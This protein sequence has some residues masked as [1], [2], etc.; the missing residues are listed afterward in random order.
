MIANNE[1]IWP[2]VIAQAT[3]ACATYQSQSGPFWL[4]QNRVLMRLIELQN[5][6]IARI[7]KT[8]TNH[9]KQ[10]TKSIAGY[11]NQTIGQSSTFGYRTKSEITKITAKLSEHTAGNVVLTMGKLSSCRCS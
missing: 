11:P 8:T 10:A 5:S 1:K 6:P 2:D 7:S 9:E 3:I 4:E